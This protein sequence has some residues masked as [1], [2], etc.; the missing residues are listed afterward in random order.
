M[1]C[2][3]F[4]ASG[5]DPTVLSIRRGGQGRFGVVTLLSDVPFCF[6]RFLGSAVQRAID[7]FGMAKEALSSYFVIVTV[8]VAKVSRLMR[9]SSLSLSLR[10]VQQAVALKGFTRKPAAE[11][12]CSRHRLEC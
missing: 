3:G 11:R 6:A 7:I 5:D 9:C 10:P 2:V 12:C 1:A 4:A 8:A